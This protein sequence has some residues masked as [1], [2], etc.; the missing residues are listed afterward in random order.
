MIASIGYAEHFLLGSASVRAS[1]S[2][3]SP[4]SSAR[5]G[6]AK[7]RPHQS[8]S[9]SCRR[10]STIT[11]AQVLRA[12]IFWIMYLMFVMVAAGGLM[13]SRPDRAD[14]QGLQDRGEPV[15]LLA[16]QM[17]ALTLAIR[18]TDLSTASA[19][20]FFGWVSD[21]IGREIHHVHRVSARAAML[22]ALSVCGHDPIGI[23]VCAAV[24]FFGVFGEI[25]SLF[26]VDQRRYVRREIRH[27]QQRHALHGEGNGGLAGAAG[28]HRADTIRA[29]GR[30]C[31]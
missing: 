4:S 23:R 29:A 31:S 24:V 27:H 7:S 26:P 5:R 19:R 11:P 9:N 1:S 3:C 12:P 10:R 8:R 25:Y 15:S 17:A 22:L 2:S 14:R 21:K 28:E 30:P 20:P 6:P 18:S 13:D 16:C